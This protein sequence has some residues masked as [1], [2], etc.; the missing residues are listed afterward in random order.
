VGKPRQ[1]DTVRKILS[2]LETFGIQV[3]LDPV[4]YEVLG[5]K[6]PPQKMFEYA[7]SLLE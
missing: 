2:E 4:T 5:V 6:L 7:T 1:N 3:E